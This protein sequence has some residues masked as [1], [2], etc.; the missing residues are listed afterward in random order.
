MIRET[1]KTGCT[2]FDRGEAIITQQRHW[3]SEGFGNAQIRSYNRM[4]ET[5]IGDA[6]DDARA[7]TNRLGRFPDHPRIRC[8]TSDC[9]PTNR[10]PFPDVTSVIDVK[11][12]SPS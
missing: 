7:R 3:M 11:R 1:V 4:L 12:E 9:R 5:G 2:V 8:D 10:A 6:E